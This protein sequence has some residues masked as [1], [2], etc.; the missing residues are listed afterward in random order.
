[1]YFLIANKQNTE[2]SLANTDF[3]TRCGRVGNN[4]HAN[5]IIILPKQGLK[6][7]TIS[8]NSY[9]PSKVANEW[10]N[11]SKS[12]YNWVIS[13][14]TQPQVANQQQ[15]TQYYHIVGICTKH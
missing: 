3:K 10:R 12:P 11:I 1:M 8:L 4:S 9:S 15:K 5:N 6:V 13:P 14:L 7:K 2:I